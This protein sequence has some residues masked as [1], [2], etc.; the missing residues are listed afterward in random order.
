MRERVVLL[1]S[2]MVLSRPGL[3]ARVAQSSGAGTAVVPLQPA[4]S[5]RRLAAAALEAGWTRPPLHRLGSAN[6]VAQL[7]L[8]QLPQIL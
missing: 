5:A 1:S 7:K 4:Q 6:A 2:L 8:S 3:G